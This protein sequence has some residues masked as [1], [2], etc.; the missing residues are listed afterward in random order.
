MTTA[1]FSADCACA[2]WHAA[3]EHHDAETD[4]PARAADAHDR[5]LP[6]RPDV[7]ANDFRGRD[8]AGDVAEHVGR[9]REAPVAVNL[10]H[11]SANR[12]RQR[13]EG[14]RE[15][16]TGKEVARGRS[17]RRAQQ[18]VSGNVQRPERSRS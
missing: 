8:G 17:Q 10:R 13:E 15:N 6:Q 14:R 3:S 11:L 5:C 2:R 1:T 4:A 18:E 9:R 16:A 7:T 12:N